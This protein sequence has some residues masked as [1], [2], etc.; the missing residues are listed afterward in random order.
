MMDERRAFFRHPAA[1][2]IQVFPQQKVLHM[3]M[4]DISGGGL[5]F[6]S[7]VF[8]EEG[9]VLK[10]R[11]PHVKPPFEASC[12]VRWRRRLDDDN[13]FEI[14]V[15]FLD[16]QTRFRVRMVEQ[17]CHIMQYRQQLAEKGRTLTFEEAAKEWVDMNAASF[18][19]C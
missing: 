4:R 15:M 18:G 3:P 2:P 14:G 16:E 19:K 17:V 8:L 7:N 1:A 11:I 6:K 12:V 9:K 5:A 13:Y 10:I